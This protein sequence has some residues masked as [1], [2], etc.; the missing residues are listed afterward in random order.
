M[1]TRIEAP[2]HA[3]LRDQAHAL[4]DT[5]GADLRDAVVSF[6]CRRLLVGTPSF[7]DEI[8]KQVLV[9]R[10]AQSLCVQGASERVQHLLERASTNR[11]VADRV[12]FAILS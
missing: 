2:E 1:I 10:H 5:L 4:T 8:V 6:D 9:E 3:G 12:S 11:H 7:L